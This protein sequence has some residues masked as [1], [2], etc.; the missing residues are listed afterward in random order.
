ML[1]QINNQETIH[2]AKMIFFFLT[3]PSAEKLTHTQKVAWEMGEHWK[4]ALD[5]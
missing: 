3:C 5:F 1:S 4:K 2:Q